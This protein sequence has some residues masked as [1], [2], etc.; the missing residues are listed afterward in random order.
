LNGLDRFVVSARQ[1][2][3][4]PPAGKAFWFVGSEED[5]AV[6]CAIN[7]GSGRRVVKC[8]GCF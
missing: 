4:S 3:T 7:P 2:R 1:R 5:L 8:F 6:G